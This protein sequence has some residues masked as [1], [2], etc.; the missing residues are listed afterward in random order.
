MTVLAAHLA[1]HNHQGTSLLAATAATVLFSV[2]VNLL[3]NTTRS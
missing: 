1:E 2:A 3:T